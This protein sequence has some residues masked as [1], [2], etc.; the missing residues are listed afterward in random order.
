MKIL[1]AWCQEDLGEK[2][3]IENKAV[4]HGLCAACEQKINAELDAKE[5]LLKAAKKCLTVSPE[6]DDLEE[7]DKAIKQAEGR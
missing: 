6:P 2:E 4:S 3:P 5:M 1:C 7:L